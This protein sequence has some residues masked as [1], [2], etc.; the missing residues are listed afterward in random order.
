MKARRNW[1]DV[2]QTLRE[3]KYKNRLLYQIKL[4]INIDRETK[5]FHGTIPFHKSSPT[6]EKKWKTLTQGGK[7]YP[8]KS[9]KVN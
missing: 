5:I 1:A 6:E 7:L 4:S 3:H 8:R 9:K 2:I